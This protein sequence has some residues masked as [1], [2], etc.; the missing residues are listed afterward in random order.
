MEQPKHAHV[1]VHAQPNMEQ[2]KHAHV[3]VHAQPGGNAWWKISPALAPTKNNG[4][5]IPDGV[6]LLR[7]QRLL[8]ALATSQIRA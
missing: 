1:H 8:K 3:H 7:W 5:S 4:K 2:P 6:H